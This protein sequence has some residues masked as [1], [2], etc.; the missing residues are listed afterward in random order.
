MTD[1]VEAKAGHPPLGVGFQNGLGVWGKFLRI[2]GVADDIEE[3]GVSLQ[4]ANNT[5]L[6]SNGGEAR[7]AP[8]VWG[9]ELDFR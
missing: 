9:K 1:R 3:A 2:E 8:S 6:G 4:T 5:V 7:Q